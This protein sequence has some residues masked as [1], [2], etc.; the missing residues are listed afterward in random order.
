MSKLIANMAFNGLS[1]GVYN[2]LVMFFIIYLDPVNWYQDFA[3]YYLVFQ[4]T[5]SVA[6][7]IVGVLTDKIGRKPML[8][9][10]ASVS[11][12]G[13]FI[14]PVS[15]QWWHLLYSSALQAT[16][17]ALLG[18]AQNCVIADVTEGYRRE[19]GY[20][21]TM[22]F[23]MVFSV[24]GTVALIIYSAIYQTLLPA[25]TYYQLPLLASAVLALIAAIPMFLISI[26][27]RPRESSLQ[28]SKSRKDLEL[29]GPKE[30]GTKN[31]KQLYKPPSSIWRNGVVI[32]MIAFQ[33]II[34]FGAGFLVPV[35][36]YYWSAIFP[37]QQ[38]VIYT[39]ALLGELG[40][41]MG[42]LAAPWIAKRAKRLGRVGTTVTC[43]FASIACAAYLAVVP[44]F[45]VLLP[46]VI[47]FIARQALMNMVNPLMGAMTMDHTPETKRGRVNSLT[48]LAFNV[49]NGI[50]PYLSEPLAN[51]VPHGYGYTYSAL[52]LI[53]TYITATALLS[54]TRKRDKL[55]VLQSRR[56]K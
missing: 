6:L 54:T 30:L 52:V 16:G 40:T 43:Q 39:I 38:Y 56:G 29:P 3:L 25:N 31:H 26:S 1:Y 8:I 45:R 28:D 23:S 9:M 11:A 41:A 22:S 21:I 42:G 34:G 12:L 37:V 55:M 47:A 36:N 4:I 33:G 27:R 7:P 17:F 50:S 10:G 44:Y 46:A 2:N 49:P 24:I 15:T 19:K 20:S 51:S 14:L 32:K 13:M 48:Q 53:S 18:T 35:F 5:M